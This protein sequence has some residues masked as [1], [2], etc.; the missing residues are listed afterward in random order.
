MGIQVYMKH[1]WVHGPKFV[2]MKGHAFFQGEITTKNALT[3]F[4]N[5]LL[6]DHWT[7]FNQTWHK[8]SL[9]EES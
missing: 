9:S 1:S 2:Q 6:K 8:V 4:K 5:L 7:N 3:K